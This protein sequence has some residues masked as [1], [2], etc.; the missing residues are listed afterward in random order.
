VVTG[1]E[2]AG[3]ITVLGDGVQE[4]KVGDPVIIEPHFGCGQCT[5]C[6]SGDYNLCRTKRV[7]GT[8][9]WPG[10]F[11]EYVVV[12]AACAYKLPPAMPMSVATLA[13]PLS[14]GLHA[15]RKAGLEPGA[16]VAILGSGTIGLTLLLGVLQHEPSR[17]ICSDLRRGNL[18]AALS[19]GAS[20]AVNPEE[21]DL[22]LEVERITK[23]LGVDV[24][25]V[26][27][28]SDAVVGQSLRITRPKGRIVLIALFEAPSGVDLREI[29]LREREL[30]GTLMYTRRDYLDAI[31]LLP[32]LEGSLARLITHRITLSQV[33][34]MLERLTRF[35]DND[36]IKVVVE[37]I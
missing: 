7:L 34:D 4:L 13:E 15:V 16:S 25:F 3:T 20:H 31:R 36:A 10:S 2:A 26:A 30:I 8:A 37:L 23:G 35:R 22:T 18:D 11:A 24:C 28:P 17:V 29:Q 32:S 5:F 33:P 14:V 6:A 21:K 12:P 19:L 9:Q 27:V 1:H